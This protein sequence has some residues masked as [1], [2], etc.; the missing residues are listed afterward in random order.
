MFDIGQRG[1]TRARIIGTLV[2]A[3]AVLS[4]ISTPAHAANPLIRG[5]TDDVWFT[6]SNPSLW[7]RKTA[8]TG[9][10]RVLIEVD[11]ESIEPN[12]PTSASQ[13]TNPSGP[14]Y[15]F[16]VLDPRVREFEHSG[17]SVAFLVTDAPRWAETPGGPEAL[18]ETGGYR[19]S[20]TAF[21]EMAQA[22][23]KRYSGSY[24]DPANPGSKLPKVSFF[25]AWAEPNLSAHLSPQWVRSGGHLVE[26]GPGIY[27]SLVNAFYAGIK[28]GDS[29]AQVINGGLGPFGDNPS[30]SNS[31]RMSPATFLRGELCV[32]G[33]SLTPTSC[34]NPAHYDILAMDPYET[35]SPLTHAYYPDDVTA[36]DLGK[37]TRIQRAALSHN[38]LLPSSHK[39][40]WVTEFSYDSKPGNPYGVSLTKQ[41]AW[42]EESFYVFWNQG[43]NTAIWYLVR[44]QPPPFNQ[45]S[46]YSGV[47]LYSG[48]AKP[49]FTAYRFP[50]VVMAYK[51]A[52]RAWGISPASGKLTVQRKKRGRWV[53]VFTTHVSAGAVFVR[54]IRQASGRLPRQGSSP[55]K[56]CL[57]ALVTRSHRP[58]ASWAA[59]RA[60]DQTA[61]DSPGASPAEG[62]AALITWATGSSGATSAGDSFTGKNA[63]RSNQIDRS[64]CQIITPAASSAAPPA[65][66]TQPS[67]ARATVIVIAQMTS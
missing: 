27:R 62:N 7:V 8:A 63:T 17:L 47:Y 43:V 50:F 15:Y 21:G 48:K 45:N 64:N 33:K 24:A 5:F 26:V 31:A 59:A 4:M 16:S 34:P 22:L 3:A 10:K 36:P 55:D 57:E 23:A 40:L 67:P 41:A 54:T 66:S 35:G 61:S 29:S 53:T 12:Q 44:D 60:P 37:L 14:E 46:Y 9:A 19:P 6:T 42:L 65:R 30:T 18:E 51:H 52:A 25:Q 32:T 13:A 28:R 56:P 20:A 11:W 2:L 38:R 39:Q 1:A 49:S 58:S